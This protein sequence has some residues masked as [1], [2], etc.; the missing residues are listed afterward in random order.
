MSHIIF[1]DFYA[2]NNNRKNINQLKEK[3]FL[4]D[5]LFLNGNEISFSADIERMLKENVNTT[6]NMFFCL[7]TTKQKYNS[8]DLLFPYNKY[9]EE[10]L[11]PNGENRDEFERKCFENLKI[12]QDSINNIIHMLSVIEMRIFITEGYDN[13]FEVM[14]CNNVEEM[15]EDIK[16]QV[17]NFFSLESKIYRMLLT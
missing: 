12:Y 1:G 5:V 11:F 15:V 14:R 8:D 7:T 2:R 3:L 17:H 4:S 9:S 16:K 13:K 6:T 10:E